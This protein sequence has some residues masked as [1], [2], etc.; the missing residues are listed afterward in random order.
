MNIFKIFLIC[1]VF[2]CIGAE[3]Q[4]LIN[5]VNLPENELPGTEL[6]RAYDKDVAGRPN[7][8]RL[9][10]KSKDFVID[11]NS[12]VITST[13]IFNYETDPTRF[14]LIVDT[15]G[16]MRRVLTINIIDVP[17]PPDCTIDPLFSSG[18]A[19]F[20]IAED[21]PLFQAI[22][23][24]NVTD[25]DIA[26][27]DRLTYNI[28]TELSGPKR[29]AKSFGVDP[30][31][32]VVSLRGED[33]LDFDAG[34]HS[35][36]LSVRVT[37]T[38][39]LFCQGTIIINIININDE[40][41][42]FE[43]F[44]MDS[45]NVTEK[46][47]IGDFVARVKATDRDEDSTVMYS[48]KTQQE[49]F[50]LDPYTGIITVLQPLNLDN[51]S[52][53]RIYHLEIEA[54]DDGN[55]TSS[56]M[57]TVFVEK[58]D[59]PISC[60]LSFSTGTGISVSVPENIPSSA[61]IYAILSRDPDVEQEVELFQLAIAVRNRDSLSL[62]SCVGTIT[63]NIQ[64]VNDESP[65]L[66]YRPEAPININENL[67]VGTKLAKFMATDRDIGDTVHY[68]FIGT[69]KEFAINEDIGEVTV[70]YPLDYEDDTI[71]KSWVLYVRVYDN[72]RTHS[73]TGTLTVILQD[74]NDNPPRCSQEIYVIELPENIPVDT[75][76]VSLTCTDQDGTIPNNNITYHLIKNTFANKTFTLTNS[77]LKIGPMNL[78]YDSTIFAGMDFKHTLFVR[79][80]DEG[81]PVLSTII[82]IILRVSRINEH[83][84]AGSMM[85]FTFSIF[86]NSP[87]DT[88][89]GKITFIDEDWPFNNIHY[90]IVGGN[91]GIPPT[92][93][94][95]SDTGMIKLLS[96]LDREV[97]SQY[98][99]TVRVIDMGNDVLPDP[100]RQRSA[101]AQ[102]TINVLNVNDEPPVCTPPH[103]ET[104]IYATFRGPI[105]PLRCSDK[106]SPQDH[107]SYSITEGN[108]NN[109]F[110]L[111]REGAESPFLAT[112]QDFQYDLLEG[113]QD[114]VTFQLLIEVT[115]E[116]GRNTARQLTATTTVIIHVLP[117]TTTQPT[118]STKTATTTI[119]TSVLRKIS[120]YWRPD[121]WFSAV[122]TL[123]GVLFMMGLYAVVWCLFKDV[124]F[125]SRLFPHCHRQK[126]QPSLTVQDEKDAE[127]VPSDRNA[128][129][130]EQP[131]KGM[132]RNFFQRET[133]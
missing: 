64:N 74:V 77:E 103:V 116:L 46:K 129:S 128:V 59:D 102:V 18:S 53:S 131:D 39:G 118:S 100:L 78:D 96:S 51:P 95:E 28:E 4:I 114:V 20:E 125:C 72:E 68:E 98:K 117:W 45:I 8:Y 9:L 31:N 81:I 58:V 34:Y 16:M 61:F 12:G 92:F 93:Y 5:P 88:L 26:H 67:P 24:V 85:E 66:I 22:C 10:N 43:P 130:T 54:R 50:A 97:T 109:Q 112:R 120:Y 133:F 76:L 87:T 110:I 15:G 44:P 132:K 56:Y 71:P 101:T 73:T 75:T 84:P 19:T 33:I 69:Q 108:T 126:S 124:Q 13:K 40:T 89:V 47:P 27:G 79:V 111:W 57:F 37:D 90:S 30:V 107:L 17:E 121:S 63:I 55:N 106:D 127:Q 21:Y 35:F 122:L 119:T 3:I 83:N 91:F 14:L 123:A 7:A 99:I 11:A 70:A 1:A 2:S 115:D 65:V 105:I 62:E 86:E 41:P 104:Q 113:V 25:E 60:D 42:Q 29:G 82:R 52:N 6:S 36:Q 94:I 49:M 38:A 48:F 80:S 23:K 32:G